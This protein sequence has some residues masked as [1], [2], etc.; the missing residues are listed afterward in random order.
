VKV[1]RK[2]TCFVTRGSGARAELLVF[3]HTG[4]GVQVPAGTVEDGE[5]FDEGALR[6]AFEETALPRLEPIAHLGSRTYELTDGWAGLRRDLQLRSRPAADSAL[7][8]WTLDRGLKV[9]VVQQRPG[10]ARVA[11]AEEDVDSPD[12]VLS[13][14]FEGWVAAE[15][16]F[17]R[18]E[19]HFYH[20]RAPED[21]PREWQ[22][23]ENGVHQFHLYWLPLVPKPALVESNQAWLDEF[24]EDLLAGVGA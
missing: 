13:A 11:Y 6:E 20:F 4:A 7:A 19:R 14:R 9:R 22:V 23:T 15:D 16:L 1:Q 2:V 21:A 3:W 12:G 10:F 17:Q 5:S 24:Y 8:R 18:L